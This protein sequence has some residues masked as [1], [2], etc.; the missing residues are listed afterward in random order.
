[1]QESKYTGVE[2][3][4]CAQKNQHNTVYTSNQSRVKPAQF[5]SPDGKGLI[6]Q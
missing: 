6:E 2:G 3:V 1:M 4:S 5:K